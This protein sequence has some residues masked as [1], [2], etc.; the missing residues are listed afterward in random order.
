MKI[1]ASTTAIAA[2][3]AAAL[4]LGTAH[5]AVAEVIVAAAPQ[6][7]LSTTD[8]T[9][10]VQSASVQSPSVQPAF[11]LHEFSTVPEPQV[12]AMML[13]GLCLIGFRAS[14]ITDEKFK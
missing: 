13:L 6:A 3:L 1:F 11:V 14:R 4:A 5:A 9:A 2:G 7:V 10:P 8:A 12:F